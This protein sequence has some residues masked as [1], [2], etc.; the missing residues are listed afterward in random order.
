MRF[1]L[2]SDLHLEFYN[3]KLWKPQETNEDK[4]TVLLLAGDIHVG[5]KAAPWITEMCERFEHVVYIL[6]N[7]EFYNHEW[8]EVKNLWKNIIMPKNFTFL[9]NDTIYFKDVRVIGGTLWTGVKDQTDD[10]AFAIWQG[11][12]R[13][14]DYQVTQVIH[15][16]G[17]KG[18]RLTVPDTM[19][20]H[21][22]TVKYIIATLERP[23]LGKTIVMTH[24]LP[25]MKCVAKRFE[26]DFLN[27]F[28]VTDLNYIIEAYD[29]KYWVHGHTH[30][31][32]DITVHNTKILCNPAGYHDIEMNQGFNEGLVFET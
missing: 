22:E 29:I 4:N 31:N 8:N 20:A 5:G 6:G 21:E 1:K 13:M 28:F 15:V 16:P 27:A 25:H 2:L 24:H 14:R 7:H 17:I 10:L 23:Y 3:E 12:Q 26:G 18:V 19:E 9:D 11:R 30:D 32:V